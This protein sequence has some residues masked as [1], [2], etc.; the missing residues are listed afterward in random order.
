M[1][2]T[3]RSLS[4][5]LA[6]LADNTS[7]DISA[8]DLRD[9]LVT[10]LG[11]YGSLS[12]FEES[13]IQNDPNTGAKLTCFDTNGSSNGMT[14]DHTDD[15]ITCNVTGVYDIAAH[16]SFSGTNSSTV[17]MRLRIDGVEQPYG[18]TRKL[19]NTDVGDASFLAPGIS[20][21]S[22]EKITIYVECDTSTDDITVVDAQF[23]ARMIG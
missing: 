3:P 17:K 18:L 12:C 1:A 7:G 9:M 2:D 11:V 6:I 10:C 20:L 4:Q 14:P 5:L 22:G 15:S 16:I 19:G 13:T 21:T 23:T 8:Q